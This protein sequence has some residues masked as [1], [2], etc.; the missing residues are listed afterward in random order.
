MHENTGRT[1]ENVVR[2]DQDGIDVNI[3]V[4]GK[5]SIWCLGN[6]IY[7]RFRRQENIRWRFEVADIEGRGNYHRSQVEG[8]TD[9]TPP[10]LDTGGIDVRLMSG[11][12]L[13]EAKEEGRFLSVGYRCQGYPIRNG[14]FPDTSKPPT[15]VFCA[16]FSDNPGTLSSTVSVCT[17]PYLELIEF[18][19]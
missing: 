16:H 1:S 7:E 9:L 2:S 18:I 11:E 12:S 3:D 5:V 19:S 8:G 10:Q 14:L 13:L 15:S 17:T 4:N 6:A